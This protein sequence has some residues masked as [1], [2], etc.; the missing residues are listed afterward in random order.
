MVATMIPAIGTLP[1]SPATYGLF[2]V[3]SRLDLPADVAERWPSLG[4]RFIPRAVRGAYRNSVAFCAD[5]EV[6]TTNVPGCEAY[7]EQD[8]FYMYDVL[9]YSV[10]DYNISD[11]DGM[12]ASRFRQ[13]L[14]NLFARELN[15]GAGSNGLSLSSTATAPNH[16]AF[17]AAAVKLVRAVAVIENEL[18]ERL[19][20]RRG[21]IHM[22]PGLL[23]QA[24][25]LCGFDRHDTP[26]GMDVGPWYTPNG[27]L[28]VADSGYVSMVQPSGQAAGGATTDWIYGSGDIFY[29][30]TEPELLGDLI[31]SFQMN[32]NT[33]K[34]IVESYGVLL[35][36]PSIVTAVLAS[37]EV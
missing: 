14:S 24:I 17:G 33:I 12:L 37:Y 9:G 22:S 20:G 6:L 3:M 18:E 26:E 31:G 28:V 1:E 13:M 4:L 32:R 27:N 21:V 34:R 7:V 36:E 8:A 10:F 19:R 30:S 5:P 35:F 2:D 11:M 29:A 16:V 23:T 15:D 25:Q